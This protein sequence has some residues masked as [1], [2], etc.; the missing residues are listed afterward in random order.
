MNTIDILYER[1]TSKF[2]MVIVT[3]VTLLDLYLV[4]RAGKEIYLLSLLLFYGYLS[5]L[6][7]FFFWMV[8]RD[9]SS[10]PMTRY[11]CLESATWR[12]Q[13]QLFP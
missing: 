11:H 2:P 4:A 1:V 8:K 7:W 6:T 5:F 13:L 3:I 9:V 10:L 12:I